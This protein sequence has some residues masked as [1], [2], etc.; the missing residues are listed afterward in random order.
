MTAELARLEAIRL[1]GE[2]ARGSDPAEKRDR[3]R[4][5][6]TLGEFADRYLVEHAELYKKPRSVE[7]DRANLRRSVLPALGRLR[8]DLV[9]RADVARFHLSRRE[10]PTNANRCLALLSHMFMM[11]ERWGVREDGSNPHHGKM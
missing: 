10:T 7:E 9:T 2:K 5:L 6:P 3:T 8:I 4:G 1:L 11:A